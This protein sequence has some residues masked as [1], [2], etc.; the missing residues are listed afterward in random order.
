M[1]GRHFDAIVIGGDSDALVAATLLAREQRTVQLLV[2]GDGVGGSA[3][4]FEFAPGY[5]AS[6]ELEAPWVPDA[7]ARALKL[8]VV[9]DPPPIPASVALPGGGLL[10][11]SRHVGDA[12]AAIREH[13]PRDAERW[14]AF[15]RMAHTLAGGFLE[16]LDAAMPPDVDAA[17]LAD[18]PSL[19]S[20]GRSFRALGRSNMTELLRVLPMA[21]QDLVDEW[22]AFEPLRAAIASA[23]VR[24]IRQGPRSGGTSYVLL[25][26]L[27]GAEP[28]ALR[29]RP[30]STAYG[31]R[32]GMIAALE[33]EAR[34]LGVEI[35]TN[36]DVGRIDVRDNAVTGVALR[37]GDES[38]SKLVLST[39]DPA[40][41]LLGLV[42]PVWLDPEFLLAVRNIKFR[43]CT[44]YVMYALDA[45]PFEPGAGVARALTG[46]VSLSSTVDSIER[47]YDAVKY[48]RT[49]DQLHVEVTMPSLRANG[50]AGPHVLVAKTQFV[51]LAPRDG[52]WDAATS[53]AL[54]DS[55]SDAI[56]RLIPRLKDVL[57][58]RVVLTP[59]DVE[60]RFGVTGGALT[61]GEI[62]LDQILFM[63][64]VPG[65][66]R[67]ATPVRGLYLAGPGTHPGPGVFGVSGLL[68]A[69]RMLAD[70]KGTR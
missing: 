28:G 31:A 26:Y 19:L 30:W 17:A 69:R 58:Y 44:A 68:A 35:Q 14:P 9:V 10:P 22:F 27:T 42:D 33:D 8:D 67:Y 65:W 38:L 21:V 41:T 52:A 60:K 51:P 13:S 47:A 7:V 55:V 70:T 45:L 6:L 63:R 48:G 12:A 64:P 11:L 54:G 49:A 57:K 36:A 16:K 61:H 5:S 23:A 53:A 46:M 25:H 43:G 29:G 24:D 1:N 50:A 32:G 4:P 2:P 39:L 3:R 37:G 15:M 62:T 18:L 40:T 56:G 34:R 59:A 20:L 66:G